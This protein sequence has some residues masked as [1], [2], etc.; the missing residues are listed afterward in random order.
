ML[1][2]TYVDER[3][4]L[5]KGARGSLFVFTRGGAADEAGVQGVYVC[6][7]GGS[8][9]FNILPALRRWKRV[10][11]LQPPAGMDQVGLA[12]CSTVG[13][14]L[15][16][17]AVAGFMLNGGLLMANSGL[18][19]VIRAAGVVQLLLGC[20]L[21]GVCYKG[22]IVDDNADRPEVAR[23]GDPPGEAAASAVGTA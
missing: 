7:E 19:P 11:S 14:G 16:L 2:T 15:L 18:P 10:N 21:G 17:A 4:R 1:K 5:G 22:G 12:Q 20:A 3:V 9:G 6:V 23:P 8:G 13:K